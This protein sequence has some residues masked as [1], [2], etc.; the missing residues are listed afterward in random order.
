[1]PNKIYLSIEFLPQS[2]HTILHYGHEL[3]ML[4]R[5][6]L[7]LF[8]DNHMKYFNT[9]SVG[10][11]RTR[12]ESVVQNALR[13]LGMRGWRRRNR[14]REDWRRLL[15][16]ARAQKG[17]YHLALMDIKYINKLCLLKSKNC[18]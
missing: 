15:R 7:T 10:K 2:K 14:E 4:C 12:W 11:V 17:V 5:E 1:M 13:V 18:F 16:E 9:R 8:C 3:K 6:R